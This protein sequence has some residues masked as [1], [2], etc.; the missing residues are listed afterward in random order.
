MGYKILQFE[1]L[2]YEIAEF[3][4]LIQEKEIES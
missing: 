1:G 2:R 3:V 4:N